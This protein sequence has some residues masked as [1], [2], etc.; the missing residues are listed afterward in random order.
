MNPWLSLIRVG[1]RRGPSSIC[2]SSVSLGPLRADGGCLSTDAAA[3]WDDML[4]HVRGHQQAGVL[5]HRQNSHTSL[6]SISV[7]AG[8]AVDVVLR[9][10]IILRCRGR[11]RCLISLIYNRYR[12]KKSSTFSGSIVVGIAVLHAPLVVDVESVDDAAPTCYAAR[13]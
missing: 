11:Q 6:R 5:G 1:G 8:H 3:T 13:L 2:F 12:S 7:P 10:H 4:Y 9:S